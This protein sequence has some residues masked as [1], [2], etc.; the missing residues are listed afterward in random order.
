MLSWCAI[1]PCGYLKKGVVLYMFQ[2][3]NLIAWL[4]TDPITAGSNANLPGAEPFH[5]YLP[6]LVFCLFGLLVTFYYYVEGRKRFVKSRPIAKYMF[7][8]YLGWLAVIEFIGLCVLVGRR[9]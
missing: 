3:T 8:R 2:G 9:Y 1:I 6:W 5:F 4:F 7:D